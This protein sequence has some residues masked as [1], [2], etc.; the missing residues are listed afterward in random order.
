MKLKKSQKQED[1]ATLA[2]VTREMA[3]P[4]FSES[5]RKEQNGA[6]HRPIKRGNSKG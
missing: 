2:T 4:R 6:H 3:R 1:N 5:A